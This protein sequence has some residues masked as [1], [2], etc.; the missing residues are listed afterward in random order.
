VFK[1]WKADVE[2]KT[3]QKLKCLKSDNGGEYD[4]ANFKAYCAEHGVKLVRTVPN[5]PQ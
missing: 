1:R 4:G 5:R 3:G 2:N